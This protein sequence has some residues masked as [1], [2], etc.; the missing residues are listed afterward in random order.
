M[1]N[2]KSFINKKNKS[3]ILKHQNLFL[4][5]INIILQMFYFQLLFEIIYINQI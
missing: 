2:I 5:A 4:Q 3:L 1:K